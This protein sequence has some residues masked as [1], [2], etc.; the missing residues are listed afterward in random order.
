MTSKTVLTITGRFDG[1][2]TIKILLDQ[3]PHCL[4]SALNSPLQVGYPPPQVLIG[5]IRV[6][7]R[8][9]HLWI[10]SLGGQRGSRSFACQSTCRLQGRVE[11]N[12]SANQTP[13]LCP[14]FPSDQV[15]PSTRS[16]RRLP[17]SWSRRAVHPFHD[18]H[19]PMNPGIGTRFHIA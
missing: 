2:E 8:Q 16:V 1:N 15:D 13:S 5:R 7:G 9:K 10:E 14:A 12:L 6:L 18:R 17:P 11:T 4:R 19:S 3:Y